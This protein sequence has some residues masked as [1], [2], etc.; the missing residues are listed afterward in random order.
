MWW[1]I[2]LDLVLV[3]RAG[4]L[5]RPLAAARGERAEGLHGAHLGAFPEPRGHVLQLRGAVGR[6]LLRRL[7]RRRGRLGVWREG[8]LG[9]LVNALALLACE[10]VGGTGRERR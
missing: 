9:V 6:G 5:R 10:R 3:P 1:E 2:S 8:R 7:P 4:Q